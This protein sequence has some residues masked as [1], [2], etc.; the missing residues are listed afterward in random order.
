MFNIN[1][2]APCPKCD[3]KACVECGWTGSLNGYMIEQTHRK[4]EAMYPQPNAHDE[5]NGGDTTMTLTIECRR[6]KQCGYVTDIETTSQTNPRRCPKCG[7]VLVLGNSNTPLY[8]KSGEY[9]L[10][11]ASL[12]QS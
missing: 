7:G 12:T 5:L 10:D 3:G 11:W 4:L 6:R 2:P 1:A 9:N 8:N